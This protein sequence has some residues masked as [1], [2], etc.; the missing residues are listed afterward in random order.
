MR[1]PFIALTLVALVAGCSVLPKRDPIRIF[2]LAPS[3]VTLPADLPQAHFSLL[4]DEPTANDM[5]DS[6]RINVRPDAGSVQVYEGASWS[7]PAPKL[8]QTALVRAFEDSGKILSVARPG[9]G[10]R[11]GYHLITDVRAFEAAYGGGSPQAVLDVQAKLVDSRDG[12]VVATRN[13]RESE[14]APSEEVDVVVQAFSRALDR[15][16]AAIVAWTLT[17]GTR[18]ESQHGASGTQR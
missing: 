13:F 3:A 12:T 18:H 9:G 6:E 10:V 2:S 17:E 15:E 7:D 11:G 8:L 1:K 4:V 14:P 16:C 5:L